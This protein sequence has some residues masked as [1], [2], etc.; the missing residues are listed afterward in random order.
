MYLLW[1]QYQEGA[2]KTVGAIVSEAMLAIALAAIALGNNNRNSGSGGSSGG[3]VSGGPC[4]DKDI[5]GYSS[6]GGHRQ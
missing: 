4:G 6:G 1:N 5:G 2:T 3:N